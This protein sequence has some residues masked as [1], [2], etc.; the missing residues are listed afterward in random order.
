MSTFRTFAAAVAATLTLGSAV[1]ANTIVDIA[2]GDDRFSTLVAAVSAAG[3]VETLQ[4]EGPFT[5][6]APVNEAFAA[7]PEGTV[8][9]LLKPENKD[10]LVQILNDGPELHPKPGDEPCR[11]PRVSFGVGPGTSLTTGRPAATSRPPL[12][13]FS[14]SPSRRLLF[15]LTVGQPIE[16]RPR[17]G[18]TADFG[19]T[20][21]PAAPP[22]SRELRPHAR[23]SCLRI[24]VAVSSRLR[25]QMTARL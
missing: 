2:A 18:G 22:E 23:R 1:Q 25:P 4:G 21:V 15:L 14:S 6:F 12:R 19:K 9:T 20:D 3:L 13:S 8:E 5:V 11:R 24:Q 10:Q 17:V 16:L 7:L